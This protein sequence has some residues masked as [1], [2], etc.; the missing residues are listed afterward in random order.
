MMIDVEACKE[1]FRVALEQAEPLE[2]EPPK[3]K[4]VPK[5]RVRERFYRSPEWRAIRAEVL[6]ESDACDECGDHAN[7]VDHIRPRW[8]HPELALDRSNL[9]PICW[10]CNRRKAGKDDCQ[11]GIKEG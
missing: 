7:Q 6:A 2:P 8:K 3:V 5:R 9:R 4:R 1:L 11:T 10:P